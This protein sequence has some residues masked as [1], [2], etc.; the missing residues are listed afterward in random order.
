[1]KHPVVIIGAGIS[2]LRAASLLTAQGISC[3][4]LEARDRIGGRVLTVSDVNRPDLGSFDLGPTWYWPQYE[5]VIT[6]L[7]KELN[8]E[9]Y[10][11]HTVG[12]MLMERSQHEP[13]ERYIVPE[14]D[15]SRSVRFKGGAQTLIDAVAATIPSGTIALKT[16]VTAI[17]LDQAG[18]ISIEAEAAGAKKEQ[19]PA[20]AVILAL[21]PRIAERRITF[22]PSLPPNLITGL[23]NKPTWM[24]GQA[25]AIAIYD[26]PFWRE[27]GLSGFVSSRIG[28]LQEIHDA[29]P[30]TGSGALFGFFGLPAAMRHELGQNRIKQLVID[31]LARLFGPLAE[32]VNSF[33]Y[34]D[35]SDDAETAVE[36]DL[37]P[38]RYHPLYG[39]LPVTG[40]WGKSIF[41]SGTET[42]SPFGGHLEGALRSAEQA[43]MELKGG[44]IR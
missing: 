24:A 15:D 21:P 36:E 38:L 37:E 28:P 26:S 34:K 9:T 39:R 2:G 33:L 5:S 35:W 16:R 8:L 4:V 29:S 44:L 3:R 19:I 20:S 30:D 40:V 18:V 23:I 7:V 31:Q 32:Q 22:S 41:F 13:P 14:N 1:M 27:S 43:V 17:R 10:V 42:N 11:Q 12:A 6:N 25:K